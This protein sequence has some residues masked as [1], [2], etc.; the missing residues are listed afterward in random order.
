MAP[1]PSRPLSGA[2]TGASAAP[3]GLPDYYS[4]FGGP[5]YQQQFGVGETVP[6]AEASSA[7]R[8]QQYN[9]VAAQITSS[10]GNETTSAGRQSARNATE[11]RRLEAEAGVAAA[12]PTQMDGDMRT[13]LI[14]GGLVAL[15][16][17]LLLLWLVWNSWHQYLG[18]TSADPIEKQKM[19]NRMFLAKKEWSSVWYVLPVVAAM[20]GLSLFSII[21]FVGNL[22]VIVLGV[23][24]L[25]QM[26]SVRDGQKRSLVQVIN[27][28]VAVV[29]ILG[30]LAALTVVGFGAFAK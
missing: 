9:Q 25:S 27:V 10:M 16:V 5:L 4:S 14:L 18:A 2:T 19:F 7:A 15:L 6:D 20:L 21:P 12:A 1:A 13:G 26:C 30:V 3:A 17:M 29:A 23:V 24:A 8:Q 22:V 28:A 11:L